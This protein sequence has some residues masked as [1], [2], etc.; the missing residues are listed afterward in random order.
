MPRVE[1]EVMLGPG[2]FYIAPHTSG[3]PE[4][5]PAFTTALTLT[6]DP[7]GN[8]VDV[9]FSEDGWSFAGQNVFSFWTPA[10]LVDP[11]VTVK[12]S[13]EYHMRGVMAQFSLENLKTALS[14]GTI[15]EDTP[16]VS[17][18]SPTLQSYV[19]ALSSSFDFLSALFIVENYGFNFTSTENCIRHIYMPYVVSVAEV[20]VPHTKGANPS[21]LGVDLQ[22][23][24]GTG[25]DIIKIDEQIE[26]P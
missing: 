23:I 1:Q 14:G 15:T 17:M 3:V 6:D 13:A 26:V 5:P 7:A 25:S 12:D 4:A 9:G 20:E 10:E 22:A 16:G 2:Y 19:P 24:K 11:V 21:L 18:T 8:W